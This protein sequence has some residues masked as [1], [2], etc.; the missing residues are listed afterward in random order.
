MDADMK[1]HNDA[2]MTCPICS[3]ALRTSKSD[4]F[5]GMLAK[6]WQ[7]KKAWSL[8]CAVVNK[9]SAPWSQLSDAH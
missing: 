6:L 3:H 4:E 7:S 5:H 8:A 9:S 2:G 1:L